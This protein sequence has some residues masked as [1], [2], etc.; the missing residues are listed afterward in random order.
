[1]VMDGAHFAKYCSDC[2]LTGKGQWTFG[3][4]ALTV[5]DVD[6]AFTKV[7]AKGARKITF[8][9]FLKALNILAEKQSMSVADIAAHC[10]RCVAPSTNATSVAEDVRLHDDKVC[11]LAMLEIMSM[12]A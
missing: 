4:K 2:N 7:K 8:D 12:H 3:R 5:T 1:M 6:L 10:L 9:E 11:S